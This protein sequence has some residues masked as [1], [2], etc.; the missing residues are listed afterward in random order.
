MTSSPQDSPPSQ[1]PAVWL[2]TATAAYE[3]MLGALAT[4]MASV[5]FE[6]YIYKADR[7]GDRFRQALVAA[8]AR[9]AQVRVLL[10]AFGSS[11]LPPDYWQGLTQAGGQMAYF[12]PLSVVRLPIRSHRKLLVVDDWIAIIG[13]FNIGDE[14]EGD[15]FTRGWR[16]LGLAIQGPAVLRLASSFELL[17]QH[18]NFRHFR[19]IRLRRSVW[20]HRKKAG[21]GTEVM[22]IGLGMGRNTFDQSLLKALRGAQEVRI[23]ASY[24]APS[25]R[26]RRALMRAAHRGSRVRLIL[27]GATDVP[28]VQAGA[29]SLYRRM[30]AAGIEIA[31]Y[32]AQVLHAKLGIIDDTVYVGSA[33]LDA[34]SLGLNYEIMIRRLDPALA[35]QGREI[36]DQDWGRSRPILASAWRKYWTW[37]RQVHGMVA[38]FFITKID[39]WYAH[40]QLRHLT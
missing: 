10:D 2:P 16:D 8:A 24:F 18:R 32:D 39:P 4:A 12:N 7:T 13:G 37:T 1:A 26:L 34:R 17:W 11:G 21:A 22:P 29:R 28:F 5:R 38:L 31:E 23:V 40:R 35:A 33:N 27:A 14:Y 36:F 3:Q 15:G 6:F 20:R 9:G 30:L 19:M 25:F